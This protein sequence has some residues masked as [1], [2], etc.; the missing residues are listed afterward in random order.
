MWYRNT[1]S[2]AFAFYANITRVAS[3]P[4]TMGVADLDHD[5]Y[6]DLLLPSATAGGLTVLRN[7]HNGT[8]QQLPPLLT[9]RAMT[10]IAVPADVS[11]PH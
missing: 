11:M 5:G 6:E 4:A 10:L 8:F 2:G 3:M 1:G 9:D 7:L